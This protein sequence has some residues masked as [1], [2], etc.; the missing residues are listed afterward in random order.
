MNLKALIV[1]QLEL[2]GS[3]R[4]LQMQPKL[5]SPMIVALANEYDEPR[6]GPFHF[7]SNEYET[8]FNNA[9]ASCRI[10]KVSG[11]R[12]RRTEN[13]YSFETSWEGIPTVRDSIT[14]YALSLPE[15]GI[16]H[17]VEV[18]DPHEHGKQYK[19]SVY[20]DS[21]RNRFVISGM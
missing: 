6:D 3:L 17:N 4:T 2:D 20:R 9:F 18:R 21:S 15:F 19:R 10:R 7:L 1:E 11:S 14:Y 16:P 13:V 12:F 5:D 8:V